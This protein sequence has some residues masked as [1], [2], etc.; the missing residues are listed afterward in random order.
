MRRFLMIFLLVLMP[1]QLS[2]A[3]LASYCQHESGVA[4]QHLGHHEHQHQAQA[5]EPDQG[6]PKSFGMADADCGFCHACCATIVSAPQKI[7]PLSIAF[8]SFRWPPDT[9]ASLSLSRPERPNWAA[10]A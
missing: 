7:P 9:L 6:K 8:V 3:A 10:L 2:W 1:L 5:D 4:A